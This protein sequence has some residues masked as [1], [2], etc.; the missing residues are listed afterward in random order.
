MENKKRYFESVYRNVKCVKK[1]ESL[2]RIK[3]KGAKET[4]KILQLS[5]QESN[6]NK[7]GN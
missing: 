5:L 6:E 1:K 2:I 7:V 4:R 3:I